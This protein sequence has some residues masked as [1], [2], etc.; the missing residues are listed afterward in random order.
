MSDVYNKLMY[1]SGTALYAEDTRDL[2]K[3]AMRE[4]ADYIA[5]L[6]ARLAAAETD[7]CNSP[8]IA[9]IE[10]ALSHDE[11]ETFLRLWFMGDFET[12]RAEWDDVPDAVFIGA[13]PLF[14]H[15]AID[16]KRG[17]VDE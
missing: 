4:A 6:T 10:Y 16:K 9:A 17:G 12:L 11:S 8:A 5:E 2:D 3:V 1:R 14:E 15:N 13:D 7:A